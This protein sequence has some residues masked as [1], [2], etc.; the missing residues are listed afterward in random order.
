[1]FS[2]SF[3]FKSLDCWRRFSNAV[4]LFILLF[5]EIASFLGHHATE[6]EVCRDV[7]L[8]KTPFNYSHSI[9]EQTKDRAGH[10][11]VLIHHCSGS[12]YGFSTCSVQRF[13]EKYFLLLI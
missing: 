12:G 13:V 10:L 3:F 9:Q 7:K 2:F 5:K 1:M 4:F 11:R 6:L 8:I